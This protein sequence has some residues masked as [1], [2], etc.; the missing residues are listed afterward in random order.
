MA[1][2]L[3]GRFTTFSGLFGIS[4]KQYITAQNYDCYYFPCNHPGGT[5]E[6]IHGMDKELHALK[7]RVTHGRVTARDIQHLSMLPS[8]AQSGK[9]LSI[10]YKTKQSQIPEGSWKS[11]SKSLQINKKQK[12]QL[13]RRDKTPNYKLY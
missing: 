9:F 5:D 12:H 6:F 1:I 4:I 3:L 7:R 13:Q 10:S 11:E 8:G 2:F